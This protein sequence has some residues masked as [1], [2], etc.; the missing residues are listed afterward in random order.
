MFTPELP[1]DF[2]NKIKKILSDN[3]P[4]PTSTP[5]IFENTKNGAIHNSKILESFNFDITKAIAAFP[6]SH[7]SYGSEFRNQS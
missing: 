6:N 2:M 1:R 7:I 4:V 5:F 3:P